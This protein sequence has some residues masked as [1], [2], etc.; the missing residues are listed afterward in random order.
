MTGAVEIAR[1]SGANLYEY[2]PPTGG[3]LKQALDWYWNHTIEDPNKWPVAAALSD[4]FPAAGKDGGIFFLPMS[5]VYGEKEWQ[6]WVGNNIV[7]SFGGNTSWVIPSLVQPL[8]LN[9]GGP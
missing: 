3:T 8:P 7:T 9:H 5:V 4:F 2:A 6:K 1:N